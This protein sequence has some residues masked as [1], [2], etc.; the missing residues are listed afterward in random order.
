MDS[1]D[2]DWSANGYRLPLRRNG[3]MLLVRF[4][5]HFSKNSYAGSNNINAV[6]GTIGIPEGNLKL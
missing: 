5:E 6:L 3:N 1:V 2:A 4:I